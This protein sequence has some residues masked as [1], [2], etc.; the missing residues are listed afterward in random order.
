LE[1]R[2]DPGKAVLQLLGCVAFVALGI[3]FVT[4]SDVMADSRHP[5]AMIAVIG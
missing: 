1:L 5:S 2:F 4:K 3:F